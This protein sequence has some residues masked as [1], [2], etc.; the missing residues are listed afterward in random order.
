MLAV[1]LACAVAAILLRVELSRQATIANAALLSSRNSTSDTSRT[2]QDVASTS[3]VGHLAATD[4]SE[5][6]LNSVRSA[7]KGLDVKVVSVAIAPHLPTAESLG[8]HD[9]SLTLQGN[10]ANLKR[11][12]GETLDRSSNAMVQRLAMTHAAPT[13]QQMQVTLGVLSAPAGAAASK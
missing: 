7:A 9:V 4:T 3:Y 1:S 13:E 5:A 6:L 2:P 10:Y 8:R 12:L 11:T